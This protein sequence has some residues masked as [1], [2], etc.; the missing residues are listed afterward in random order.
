MALIY[1]E[2]KPKAQKAGL[3]NKCLEV[4]KAY[5]E[6]EI[7]LTLRQLYYQ[8]VANDIIPNRLSEYKKLT[9]LITDARYGGYIPWDA[10]EDRMRKPRKHPAWKDIPDGVDSLLRQYRTDWWR[11][12]DN[13]VELWCEKDALASVIEPITEELHVKL[14]INR[15]YTSASAIYDAAMRIIDQ[16][17]K[18]KKCTLLY[19]G[20][21][22]PSGL[23]MVRDIQDRIDEITAHHNDKLERWQLNG[24]GHGWSKKGPKENPLGAEAT[25]MAV[26]VH[27]ALTMEQVNEFHPP[28]NPA[29]M[30][31]PRAKWYIEEHGDKSWEVDALPPEEMMDLVRDSIT[32]YI[33]DPEDFKAIQDEDE[34]QK[35][36]L[37]DLVDKYW[38]DDEEESDDDAGN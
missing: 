2:Y 34:R 9:A 33:N 36:K 23:D 4:I 35:K 3:L 38:K 6:M 25:N 15:G 1:R 31:D 26:V 24:G 18:G 22:D 17:E 19:L 32:A 10:I 5:Q 20:D 11:N 27:I 21:H 13:Y 29:K 12:Q 16:F 8:L 30:T 7:K 28:P 14:S 37:K